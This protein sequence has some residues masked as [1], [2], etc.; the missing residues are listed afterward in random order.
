MD[1][2]LVI[3]EVGFAMFLAALAVYL[4]IIYKSRVG[5]KGSK[6]RQKRGK[7]ALPDGE[8]D[9]NS[10]I[11]GELVGENVFKLVIGSIVCV[12]ALIGMR[13]LK[14]NQQLLKIF[15]Q[16]A[17]VVILGNHAGSRAI[18][19]EAFA[20]LNNYLDGVLNSGCLFAVVSDSSP[21][22]IEIPIEG[23]TKESIISNLK[24]GTLRAD[25]TEVDLLQ[26]IQEARIALTSGAAE[27]IEKKQIIIIDTGISTAGKFNF[28]DCDLWK[29]DE[30]IG[31]P[32]DYPDINK[33]I[34]DRLRYKNQIDKFP[35][36]DG[37]DVIIIGKDEGFAAEAEY[38]G[39]TKDDRIF[40]KEVWSQIL[41][42]LCGAKSVSFKP[43][44]GWDNQ[45]SFDYLYFEDDPNS[46]PFVSSVMF[47]YKQKS[48][49]KYLNL[50]SGDVKKITLGGK[51]ESRHLGFNV[52][53]EDAFYSRSSAE[54]YLEP[55]AKDIIDY[56]QFCPGKTVI[57]ACSVIFEVDR[58]S[59]SSFESSQWRAEKTIELLVELGVDERRLT[60]IGL[61]DTFPWKDEK[62]GLGVDDPR[63]KESN[64]AIWLILLD[65][66]EDERFRMLYDAYEKGQ[67]LQ[68][69]M[70][71]I[72]DLIVKEGCIAR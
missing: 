19:E 53:S 31:Y 5:K 7:N 49:V 40:I 70:I 64:R 20:E 46:Y 66:D 14:T 30:G 32:H 28:I 52:A 12:L 47:N 62:R 68:E 67:L 24:Q 34:I 60:P 33:E 48:I 44:T 54:K 8:T 61:G 50:K 1:I 51:I 25:D 55:Y 65:L 27:Y 26:A 35:D 59:A 38:L 22:A 21:Y 63:E 6:E 18:P 23:E 42:L 57:V 43:V 11:A 45:N 29:Y 15:D 39:L 4:W 71:H 10:S 2:F 69:T 41:Q 9:S 3:F 17:L 37:I 56:L 16:T 58:N 13:F 36:L 72:N